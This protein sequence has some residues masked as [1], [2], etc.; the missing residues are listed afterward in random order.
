[1]YV[2]V[3]EVDFVIDMVDEYFDNY[4]LFVYGIC[5]GVCKVVVK[6]IGDMFD[7]VVVKYKC[8]VGLMNVFGL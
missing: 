6:E 7:I 4:C 1:M 3:G 2:D 8:D 5:C